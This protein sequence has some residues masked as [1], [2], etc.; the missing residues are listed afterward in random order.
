MGES[1][2]RGE[3]GAAQIASLSVKGIG[4]F[5]AICIFVEGVLGIVG[6][7]CTKSCVHHEKV[8][9][10]HFSRVLYI[11][12]KWPGNGIFGALDQ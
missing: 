2:N 4:T 11:L 1:K 9:V 6:S 3:S 12:R 5:V 10:P 8:A 7:I